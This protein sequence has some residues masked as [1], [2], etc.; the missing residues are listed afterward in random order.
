MA[1]L[2][3]EEHGVEIFEKMKSST[4]EE[5]EG[6][7]TK[8]VIGPSVVNECRCNH[9]N[10]PIDVG[11]TAVYIAHYNG[12]WPDNY[13]ERDYIDTKKAKVHKL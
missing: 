9:C 11:D 5:A 4:E 6:I 3:C 13:G 2:Y 7:I 12:N 1:S 8:V 10:S